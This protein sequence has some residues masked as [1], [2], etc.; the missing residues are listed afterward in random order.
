MKKQEPFFFSKE[1]KTKSKSHDLLFKPIAL[2]VAYNPTRVA[3][4]LARN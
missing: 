2:I 3:P 4:N 1:N